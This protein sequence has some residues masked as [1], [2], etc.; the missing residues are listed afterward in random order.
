[1]AV[2]PLD[3]GFDETVLRTWQLLHERVYGIGIALP[4]EASASV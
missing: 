4:W 1:M 2:V 3:H